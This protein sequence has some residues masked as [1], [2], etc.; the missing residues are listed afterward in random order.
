[1]QKHLCKK[2]KRKVDHKAVFEDHVLLL[3]CYSFVDTVWYVAR[4]KSE[5]RGLKVQKHLCKNRRNVDHKNT[6]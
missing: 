1:V 4:K 2:K 3:M 5:R 6:V